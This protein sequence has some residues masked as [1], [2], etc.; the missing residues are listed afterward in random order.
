MRLLRSERG[1]G[2]IVSFAPAVA[3]LFFVTFSG[4]VLLYLATVMSAT[5]MA[6]REGARVYGITHDTDESLF[7]VWSLLYETK[8]IPSDKS[9]EGCVEEKERGHYVVTDS[10]CRV[11]EI[12]FADDG[13]WATC[14]IKYNFLK[15]NPF[16]KL[17][18]L[19]LSNDEWR[20]NGF[21]FYAKGA[22]KHEY[23]P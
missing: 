5:H 3:I 11:A 21:E 12:T 15:P 16:R 22:A 23:Q 2:E 14:R 18:R 19:V 10:S 17:P 8:M 6:A 4:L 7:K 1:G 13:T 9:I 20:P